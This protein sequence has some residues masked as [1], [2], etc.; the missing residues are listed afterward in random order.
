[1]APRLARDAGN[2]VGDPMGKSEWALFISALSFLVAGGSLWVAISARRLAGKVGPLSQRIEAIDHLREAAT[3]L[4]KGDPSSALTSINEARKLANI[5]FSKVV[6]SKLARS[7]EKVEGLCRS[8]ASLSV[9]Q[10]Y[11]AHQEEL[12]G[13]I[14]QMNVE[15]SLSGP[16]RL[17][18]WARHGRRWWRWMRSTG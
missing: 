7:G 4:Q 13:I 9:L 6:R 14:Y 1:M 5:V 8:Q 3:Y 15:G 12:Q 16:A 17:S 11:P 10:D 18:W 2:G